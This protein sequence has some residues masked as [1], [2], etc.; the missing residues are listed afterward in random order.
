MFAVMLSA[1]A[2]AGAPATQVTCLPSL[3]GDAAGLTYWT[4]PPRIELQSCAATLYASA[5]PLERRKIRA[6][7]PH[8]FFP[9]VVGVG[10]LVA[11]HEAEHVGL[12]S[13]DE[14]L[15]ERT[16]YERL[17]QLLAL[18]PELPGAAAQAAQYNTFVLATYH[19]A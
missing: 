12:A 1:L 18:V 19:C 9:Q 5:S 15:V 7:N 4:S 11:L 8:V 2:L 17:P 13:R 14:C 3:P 6:L 10:L 16:A